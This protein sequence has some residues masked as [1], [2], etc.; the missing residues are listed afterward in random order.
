MQGPENRGR[1]YAAESLTTY[2]QMISD[3]IGTEKEYMVH[4]TV[5]RYTNGPHL[6]AGR[7]RLP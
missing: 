7:K 5:E 1:H 2:R 6:A 3:V 4:E